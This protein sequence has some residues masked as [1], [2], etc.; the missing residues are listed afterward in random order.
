MR[1][2]EREKILEKFRRG[3][4]EDWGLFRKMGGEVWGR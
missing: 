3:A 1:K 2:K 4:A